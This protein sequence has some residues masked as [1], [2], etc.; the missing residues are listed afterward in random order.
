MKTSFIMWWKPP[1]PG[2]RRVLVLSNQPGFALPFD[3]ASEREV[4]EV[5]A[6]IAEALD[7]RRVPHERL[8]LTDSVDPLLEALQRRSF[9]TVFNICESLG[10]SPLGEILVASALERL[11]VPYTGCPPAALGL[12]LDKGLSKCL[13][14]MMGFPVPKFFVVSQW[15]KIPAKL[16]FRMPMIVKPLLQDASIGI[17]DTSVVR[18]KKVMK[19]QVAA[20]HQQYHEPAIVEEFIH[21]REFNVSVI[22][23]HKPKAL[24]VSEI[25]FSGLPTGLP[26]IVTY[27]AKWNKNDPRYGGTVPVVP[28]PIPP[29]MTRTL[30]DLAVRSGRALGCR[31]YWRVDFRVTKNGEPR[32]VEVNPNPDLH[33]EAGLARALK[34]AGMTYDGFI[35][36]AIQWSQES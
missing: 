12:C 25:D 22:G 15:E 23:N 35:V 20:V 36:K 24:P 8:W 4:D 21:G 16:P 31:H 32:I 33:P 18:S 27:E 3:E 5:V 30:Q 26:K 19:E 10:G 7:K 2:T 11:G 28:A 13:L 17:H 9:S 29:E 1:S 6:G 14:R 34:A